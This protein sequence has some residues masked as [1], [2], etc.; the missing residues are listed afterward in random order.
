MNVSELWLTIAS[1]SPV[2]HYKI[3]EF[4]KKMLQQWDRF[5]GANSIPNSKIKQRLIGTD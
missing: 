2:L 5:R 3:Y 4:L 1:K